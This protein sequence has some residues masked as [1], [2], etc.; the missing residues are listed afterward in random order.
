[1]VLFFLFQQK[2]LKKIKNKENPSWPHTTSELVV[3]SRAHKKAK[4][5]FGNVPQLPTEALPPLAGTINMDFG[6]V[7]LAGCE[8]CVRI[9]KQHVSHARAPCSQAGGGYSQ[10]GCFILGVCCVIVT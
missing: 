9:N 1:M 7:G 3:L 4:T 8:V 2:N 5:L 6:R 10:F